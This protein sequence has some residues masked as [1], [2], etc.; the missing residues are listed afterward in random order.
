MKPEGAVKKDAYD[1][2]GPRPERTLLI[3]L[4]TSRRDEASPENRFEILTP[5]S[6]SRPCHR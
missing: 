6:A 2:D 1:L 4:I 3:P 5:V